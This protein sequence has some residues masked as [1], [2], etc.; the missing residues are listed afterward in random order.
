MIETNNHN[1]KTWIRWGLLLL[2][3]VVIAVNYYS[4][5]AMSS[6]KETMQ[7]ELGF[8]TTQYGVI[9]SFYSFP[10]TFLLMTVFGGIFLDRFGIRKTGFL[11]TLFCALGVFLTA[12]GSSDMFREGGLGYA[13]FGSFLK[14]FSPELKVMVLGRLLFGLGAETSIVVINK[15]I[16]KWFK[17]KELAFAFAVNLAIAR[18]GTAAALILSP[19]LADTSTGWTLALWV[20][21]MLMGIGL[22]VFVIY[23]IYD[24]KIHPRHKPARC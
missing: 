7:T 24:K 6:I 3:S 9:V 15:V 22:L 16:V 1:V 4:Y 20:A 18:L 13:F 11:F 10:N 23:M 12:Y 19:I 14:Q 21:S 2:V 8:S 17:G 5:D